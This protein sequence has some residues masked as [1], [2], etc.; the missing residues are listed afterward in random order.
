MP[1]DVPGLGV[2]RD[3]A[4]RPVGQPVPELT[5][6]LRTPEHPD[7][8]IG[9][10]LRH[11]GQSSPEVSSDAPTPAGACAPRSSASADRSSAT[12]LF[13]AAAPPPLPPPLMFR[14]NR[15]RFR[16]APPHSSS[17]SATSMTEPVHRSQICRGVGRAVLI[18]V[19]SAPI[20]VRPCA[21]I[22][23]AASL[24][25]DQVICS[26]IFLPLN[27]PSVNSSVTTNARLFA[28]VTF[29][30]ILDTSMV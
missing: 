30:S 1:M 11:H 6:L 29:G 27:L 4:T 24:S 28:P 12:G 9:N 20:T 26:E 18:H 3:V 25:G 19:W 13:A 7:L 21:K 2:D 15:T 16:A 22:R 17:L 10:A 8:E 14:L 23:M 5:D